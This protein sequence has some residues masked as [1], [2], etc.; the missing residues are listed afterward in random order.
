MAADLAVRP[1]GGA[2]AHGEIAPDQLD[3]I[4]RTI[5]VGA[6]SDELALFL[7]Q[8][9]RTGLDPLARQIHFVK[10]GGKGAVQVGIDGYR[11]IADRTGQYAGNDD[12]EYGPGDPPDWARVTVWKL[13]QGQRCPFTATA[14]WAEYVPDEKQNFMWKK[15]PHLMIAK[16]AESLA[17]RKAFPAELSGVYT[18]AEMDQAGAVDPPPATRPQSGEWPRPI[19]SR[20]ARLTAEP[21][22]DPVPA[23]IVAD[24]NRMRGNTADAPPAAGAK[25]T[26]RQWY[27]ATAPRA[28]ELGIKAPELTDDAPDDYVLTTCQWLKDELR[29]LREHE[30][31]TA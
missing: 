25:Q 9:K 23:G 20:V 16:V 27:A 19:A 22:D 4:K 21:V 12:A 3:L 24:T 11:L 2:L 26:P 13:V 30:A 5:A 15:L 1:H 10:R 8:A 7:Y 28:R 14:R 17:L 29:L 6:S 31:R 18:D